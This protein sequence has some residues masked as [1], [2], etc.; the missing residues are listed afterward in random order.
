MNHYEQKQQDRKEHYPEQAEKA[1]D[2]TDALDKRSHDDKARIPFVPTNLV[3][4]HPAQ[5]RPRER[6]G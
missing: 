5:H 2:Q 6:P 1:D 3:G 4:P